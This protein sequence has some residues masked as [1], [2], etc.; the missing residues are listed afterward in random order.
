M[1]IP[2]GHDLLFIMA[3]VT[4]NDLHKLKDFIAAQSSQISTIQ[5]QFTTMQS[6]FADFQTQITD[7]KISVGKVESTLQA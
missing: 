7:I 1:F 3:T 2:L 5:S 6:Q 4:D